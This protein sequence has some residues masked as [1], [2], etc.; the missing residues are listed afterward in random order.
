[1]QFFSFLPGIVKGLSPYFKI[2]DGLIMAKPKFF[3]LF[4]DYE[5][6]FDILSDE[7]AGRLIKG[8]YAFCNERETPDFSD[9]KAILA[10]YM[11]ITAQIARDFER[12]EMKCAT[13]KRNGSKK[14]KQPNASKC[15]QDKD[16]DKDKDK[17]KDE[18]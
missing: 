11:M 2:K 18:D 3:Q 15:K 5:A 6:L 12:Y 7:E 1:M 16:N 14:Q 4:L 17:D 10:L 8:I 9:N 13:L